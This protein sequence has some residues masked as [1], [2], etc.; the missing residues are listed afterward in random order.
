MVDTTAAAAARPAAVEGGHVAAIDG[1]RA[2]A[3][4]TVLIFHLRPTA[5]PGGFVGVDVFFVISGFVV[6]RS[7]AAYP[8]LGFGPFLLRFYR[9]RAL[10][11]VPALAACL[12][13]TAV[14]ATLFV[15]YAVLS[16]GN[17]AVGLSAYLGLGNVALWR[18]SGDYFSP[19]TDYNPFTH[20]W[21]LGV[22]EQFYL[23]FPM[24]AFALLV[25]RRGA[26]PRRRRRLAVALTAGLSVG[27]LALAALVTAGHQTFAFYLLPTRFWELG[28]GALLHVAISRTTAG[29]RPM[30]VLTAVA[31]ALLAVSLVFADPAAFPFPWAVPPVAAAL[32]LIWVAATD[33]SP[34]L[35]R[36]LSVEPVQFLGRISYGLYLWHFPVIVLMRWTVGID[37]LAQQLLAA[38]ISIALATASHALLETPV[39]SSRRVAARSDLTVVAGTLAGVLV[40][41]G[42]TLLIF[43][44]KP[45]LSLSVTRDVEVWSPR[46]DGALVAGGCVV[47]RAEGGYLGGLRTLYTPACAPAA[48]GPRIAVIGNSHA[49]AYLGLL[50]Q[51]SARLGSPVEVYQTF[52]CDFFSFTAAQL[53]TRYGQ[54]DGF[55]DT[56][57]ADLA[58][59][60]RPG[61]VLFL[62]KLRIE[63]FRDQGDTPPVE[64]AALDLAPTPADDAVA[65][66]IAGQLQPLLDR[67]VQVVI[68]APKPVFRAAPFRCADWFN[69]MN[70]YCAPGFRVERATIEARRARPLAAITAY[71]AVTPGVSVWDPLPVL[72]PDAVCSAFRDGRPL[73]FDADHLSQYGNDVL[74]PAFLHHVGAPVR[75]GA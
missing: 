11:I 74:L 8:P 69:R 48:T 24:L 41:V 36:A 10:R 19:T 51:A 5:L 16:R 30:P 73:Y 38:A 62:P 2:V 23:L 4:V 43:H 27:S 57:L 71:A 39:R 56:I 50:Q 52:H 32:A 15:P 18:W 47:D 60:L 9:K 29:P 1:L 75:D 6:A 53:G 65:A 22:E 68:E 34:T 35:D 12:L 66:E 54:C 49:G 42:A 67:G 40:A 46:G 63:R 58:S 13:A 59:R 44:A 31:A 28:A 33:A 61:D 37:T 70:P 25:P 64:N 45:A 26:A 14:L 21:S 20:T 7:I 72:C 17:D 3:I 55:R